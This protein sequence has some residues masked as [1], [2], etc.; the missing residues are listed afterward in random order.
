MRHILSS[1]VGKEI[2]SGVPDFYSRIKDVRNKGDEISIGIVAK[3]SKLSDAYLSLIESL[4]IAG[5]EE[6]VNVKTVL[7]N[8]EDL[9]DSKENVKSLSKL[10]GV[11]VAGGF[12]KR[13][14]DGKIAAIKYVREND[15]PFLGICLGLQMAVVEFAKNIIG[16]DAVSSEMYDDNEKLLKNM[17]VIVDFMED[18]KNIRKKGGTMRLGGYDCTLEKDTLAK[19]LYGCEDIR[20]RHR[21][22]YEVQGSF[23]SQL[24]NFGMKISGKHLYKDLDGK[25]QFLVEIIELSQ[26]THPY[27]I[28]TQSHPEFLSRPS[29]PHPLFRGLLKAAIK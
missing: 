11:V 14:M 8:S 13:G 24:E 12:G 22:R 19:E 9:I 6:G 21:H 27:F 16:L 17:D 26:D 10:D 4:K 28:A 29:K 23:V 5:V 1:F 15:I 7:I 25:N 20:E 2:V 3:Y 18:Q